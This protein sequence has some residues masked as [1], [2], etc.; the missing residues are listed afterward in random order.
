M[1]A[2]DG[3]DDFA[4][5]VAGAA[6]LGLTLSADALAR[7]V[8]YRALLLAW[9][10]R[11]NLT[12]IVEPTQMV[13][14]HFLDSLCCVAALPA[15]ARNVGT[16]LLDV[17]SGAGFPGV[18]LA[19]AFP[20]WH[21]TL[22]EATAKKVRFL[23]AIIATVGLR[24]VRAV[25]ERAET[26]ARRPEQRGAYDVVVARAVA[27]LPTLLE[28]CCP[29]ARIGGHVVLP[30]KGDL[31]AEIAAGHRAAPL[32]GARV[33]DPIAITVPPLDDGRVLLLA[34]QDRSC[35]PGYPRA[36]GAPAKRP[37]GR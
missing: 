36:Q 8:A 7:F 5:L 29:F 23:E 3:A 35:P 10:T 19:I 30:K 11:I 26:F 33:L 21:I 20:T 24:N 17:G 13:T 22:V 32:L 12:A 6:A 9:N 34:R 2:A 31:A 25:A 4:P 28:Y 27:A 15:A 18:P 1:S 37:L 16:A 14:H